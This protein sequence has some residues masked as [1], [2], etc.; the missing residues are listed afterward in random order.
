MRRN[1][2]NALDIIEEKAFS[3]GYRLGQKMFGRITNNKGYWA[4]ADLNDEEAWKKHN[5]RAEKKADMFVDSL[6]E[7]ARREVM[8]GHQSAKV[9]EMTGSA[10]RREMYED[11]LKSERRRMHR[12]LEKRKEETAMKKAAEAARAAELKASE[13]LPA[14]KKPSLGQRILKYLKR[15]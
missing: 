10:L 1:F 13:L 3:E 14:A 15:K 12:Q 4:Y 11:A 9:K 5:Q 8:T 2:Y 7:E 6:H